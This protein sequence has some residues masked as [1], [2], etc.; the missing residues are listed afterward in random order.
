MAFDLSELL[1]D[2]SRS[3]TG[4]EQIEYIGLSLIDSDPNN[5]YQ[6]SKVDELADNIAT[7]GLQQP[8][9]VRRHPEKSGRYMIVS[10]HRRR[11]AV[12]LL[13]ADDPDRWQEVPC[14]VEQD[15][16]SP[17]LQ[18]LR[19]IFA[20]SNTRALTP[21][22]ISEQALQVE[23]L[24]YQLKEEGHEFPG[25]MRDHVAQ[26]VQVSKTKLA[27]LKVIRENLADFW[28]SDFNAN[29]LHES[30]AYYLA[31]LPKAD[32]ELIFDYATKKYGDA[33]RVS[34]SVVEAYGNRLHPMA[35][36]ICP[37]EGIPC[38]NIANKKDAT[39]RCGI[40]DLHPCEKCCAV[41]YKLTTCQYACPKLAEQIAQKKAE[42]REQR[43][44]EKLAA[45]T[46]D[47]PIV[48]DITRLW[49]RF[50]ELRRGSAITVRSVVEAL[51]HTYVKSVHQQ[52][53]DWEQGKKIDRNT[54]LPYGSILHHEIKTLIKMADLFN[55]SID[56]M[57]CRTDCPDL[58]KEAPSDNV[59]N[60]DTGWQTG[61]PETPGAYLL[62]LDSGYGSFHYEKWSWDGAVWKDFIG[63]HDPDIDGEIRGWIPMPKE[64][65]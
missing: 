11:A 44:Q 54:C 50:G 18:Q 26:V 60:L 6:L 2:V 10:G 16:I 4:R 9:R 25:R 15:D 34:C 24:L 46:K 19:L 40:Y 64:A 53:C 36:L 45:E 17:A 20:N 55:C 33:N 13:A 42:L 61:D 5:F 28:L 56:Y 21:A 58:V 12:E 31:Q 3:D 51:G 29:A 43:R 14:I 63:V 1:K 57:L 30:T 8:I 41:C 49:C 47:A 32:Q 62:M 37:V 39:I 52:Y 22:E 48:E 65:I 59:S 23:K 35:E 7:C 38:E 27:R